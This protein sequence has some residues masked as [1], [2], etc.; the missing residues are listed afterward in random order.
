MCEREHC[1]SSSF[2]G[3]RLDENSS[4]V[5]EAGMSAVVMTPQQD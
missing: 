5:T 2:N 1:Q 4:A 3:I